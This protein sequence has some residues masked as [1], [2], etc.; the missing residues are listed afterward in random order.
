MS[1]FQDC[2]SR[3]NGRYGPTILRRAATCQTGCKSYFKDSAERAKERRERFRACDRQLK[4]ASTA[5]ESLRIWSQSGLA[6]G[7]FLRQLRKKDRLN[8][9]QPIQVIGQGGYGTVRIVRHKL[10]RK[11]FALKTMPKAK[12]IA[13]DQ[14]IRV[15]TERDIMAQSSSEWVVM[16]FAAFQDAENLHLLME[17]M[18]GGDLL[19]L[20]IKYDKF[21]EDITRFYIAEL[22][23]ALEYMH[24]LGFI[25]RDIKPDN[26]L[27]DTAGHLKLSDFGLS[28]TTSNRV[29]VLSTIGPT[30]DVNRTFSKEDLINLNMTSKELTNKR[31]QSR[32]TW[33]YSQVGTAEYIASEVCKGEAYSYGCDLW[34]MGAIMYEC[35][36]G[37]PPFSGNT[38]AEVFLKIVN[39]RTQLFIT[40]DFTPTSESAV[41]SLLCDAND[42]LS[43]EQVK[44]HSFFRGVPWE[45][46]RDVWPPFSPRLKSDVD[47]SNFAVED[48]DQSS[49]MNINS[50]T[51]VSDTKIGYETSADSLFIGYTFR[52]FE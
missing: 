43:I 32:G 46:L 2:P 8:D 35:L 44:C 5:E 22:V 27:I 7:S 12:S 29:P 51:L 42:R 18:P 50:Q 14:L 38:Q 34:S 15:K 24:G 52:R 6:E 4:K 26:I 49:V 40:G 11:T 13:W 25:H 23:L 28:S 3:D 16:L 9:F 1:S 37:C 45:R 20:L 21:T 33:A 10:T 19:G 47:T 31:R 48:F 39:W 30:Q 36:A 17:Y 41:R